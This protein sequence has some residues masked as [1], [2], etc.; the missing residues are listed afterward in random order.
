MTASA[1]LRIVFRAPAGA[2]RG[3]GHLTRCLALGRALGVRPL[4][5][6]R[7]G[8]KARDAALA[9]GVD[10]LASSSL[11]ALARLRPDV[12]IIDD[13]VARDAERWTRAARRAGAVVVTVHDLGL[14]GRGGD[15]AIDGSVTPSTRVGRRV[16]AGAR[17]AVLDPDINRQSAVRTRAPQVLIALGGGPHARRAQAIAETIAASDPRA[18][19][20]I[21]GGFVSSAAKRSSGRVH[22]IGSPRGLAR[23]L[24]RATVAVVGGGRSLY[25]A[26]A[27]G[28][29]AVGVPVVRS[30]VP[31]IDAFARRRAAVAVPYAAPARDAASKVVDL[32][33]DKARRAALARSSRQLVDGRGAKRAAAAVLK[34]AAGGGR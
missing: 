31:T 12:L 7:G 4:V 3:F 30:Q 14:G 21:A 10:V 8:S 17:F 2:G 34:L 25:E 20:R 11:T 5:S 6:L 28:V 26:A 13:P 23:E 22:W 15:L 19:I 27:M 24:A 32:L 18:Q 16:L 1:D 29:P 33:Q 9:L